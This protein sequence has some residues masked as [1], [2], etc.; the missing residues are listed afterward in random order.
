MH[1]ATRTRQ[2][3]FNEKSQGDGRHGNPLALH[4]WRAIVV[5]LGIFCQAP[6]ICLG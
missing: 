6:V 5:W 3:R 4:G 2:A 1:K